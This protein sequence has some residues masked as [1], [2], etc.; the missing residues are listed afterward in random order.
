MDY[1]YTVPYT[2]TTYSKVT[3]P[4]KRDWASYYYYTGSYYF[5]LP[6]EQYFDENETEYYIADNPSL[7]CIGLNQIVR[8]FHEDFGPVQTYYKCIGSENNRS[9]EIAKWEPIYYDNMDS[10][11]LR[12]YNIDRA[13]YGIHFDIRGYDSTIWEKVYTEGKGAFVLISHLNGLTPA[14]ELYPDPPRQLPAA[15]YIDNL[16]SDV[17]YRIH[18]P[19][20]YG[21]Q[22]KEV[23]ESDSFISDQRETVLRYRYNNT[24]HAYDEYSTEIDAGIYLNLKGQLILFFSFFLNF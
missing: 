14:L 19:S 4:V 17:Y 15:P 6:N 21:L 5:K 16:S 2:Y 18:V 24:N 13:T 7:A 12:N 3:S 1:Q 23:K 8:L 20:M 10:D 11:Y 22:L 9:G